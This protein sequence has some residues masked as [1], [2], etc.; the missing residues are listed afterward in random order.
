MEMS[1]VAFTVDDIFVLVTHAAVKT[2]YA[3]VLSYLL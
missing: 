2:M 1:D 3:T